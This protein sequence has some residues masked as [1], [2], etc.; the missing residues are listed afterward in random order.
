MIVP[1][2]EQEAQ[3]EADPGSLVE[4]EEDREANQPIYTA[5]IPSSYC[6]S[7]YIDQT[8]TANHDPVIVYKMPK[9]KIK[10]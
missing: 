10:I 9:L 3:A 8:K 7:T 2:A 4:A 1:N 6:T 5:P